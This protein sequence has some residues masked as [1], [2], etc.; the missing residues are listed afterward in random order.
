MKEKLSSVSMS[1]SAWCWR[2][3]E[4]YRRL[5]SDLQ[6]EHGIPWVLSG[7][8]RIPKELKRNC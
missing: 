8:F 5:E 7:K 3:I 2:I 6:P 1:K 4:S